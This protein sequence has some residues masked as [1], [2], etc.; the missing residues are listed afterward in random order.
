MNIYGRIVSFQIPR[1]LSQGDR[2]PASPT[3]GCFDRYYWL[4]R[5]HDF[6]NARFQETAL[7]LVLL[8]K[9]GCASTHNYIHN[10]RLLEWAKAAINF[11]KKIQGKNGSYNEVYPNENS[12]VTTAFTTYAVT[13]ALLELNDESLTK[14]LLGKILQAGNWLSKHNNLDVANQMAGALVAL[15]NIYLITREPSF[16]KAVNCKLDLI[17][18]LQSEEGYFMEYGGYDIGYLSLCISYLSKYYMKAKDEK[19]AEHIK[20]AVLFVE[21]RVAEDGNY[22]SQPT[23]RGTQYIYPHGFKIMG[24]TVID[25][26]TWGLEKERVVN[27]QWMDDRFCIPLTIDYFQTYLAEIKNDTR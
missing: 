7:L 26:H 27:P 19:I 12:F 11:W 23:S 8:Y 17:Y 9:Y 20:K 22:D 3:Y 4:Y 16:L 25:K 15:Y 5:L 14:K 21:E 10:R 13:E 1:I 24:S 2:D 6:P 18:G